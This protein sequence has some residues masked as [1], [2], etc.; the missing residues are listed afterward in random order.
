MDRRILIFIALAVSMLYGAGFSVVD[1]PAGGYAQ[2]GGVVVA[3][4]WIAVG[5]LGRDRSSARPDHP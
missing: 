1:D 2:I 3:L 4:G 5:V